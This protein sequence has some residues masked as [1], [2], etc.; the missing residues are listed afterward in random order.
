MKVEAQTSWYHIRTRIPSQTRFMWRHVSDIL[1][2]WCHVNI[3]HVL[4][5][6]LFPQK[7]AF[8][9]GGSILFFTLTMSEWVC[10]KCSL[11]SLNHFSFNDPISLRFILYLAINRIQVEFENC[12]YAPFWG[13]VSHDAN[14]CEVSISVQ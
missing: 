12:C 11:F 14:N 4:L 2:K 7:T 6:Y 10:L 5:Q 1:R 13:V 9:S 3:C 8:A